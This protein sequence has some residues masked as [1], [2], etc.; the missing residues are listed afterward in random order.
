MTHVATNAYASAWDLHYVFFLKSEWFICLPGFSF[1]KYTLYVWCVSG[2]ELAETVR[3]RT[4]NWKILGSNLSAL[5]N[6]FFFK[7]NKT[8]R[9]HKMWL[10]CLRNKRRAGYVRTLKVYTHIYIFILYTVIFFTFS[11]VLNAILPKFRY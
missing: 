6:S 8:T 5:T 3:F 7:E 10:Q 2:K 11:I 4:R 9:L 1:K